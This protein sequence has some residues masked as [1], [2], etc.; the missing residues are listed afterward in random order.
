MRDIGIPVYLLRWQHSILLDRRYCVCVGT[1]H[2]KIVRFALGVSQGSISG[3]LLFALYLSTLTKEI[4]STVNTE[5]RTVEFADYINLWVRLNRTADSSYDINQTQ[6]ALNVISDWSERYGI[7]VSINQSIKPGLW[8]LFPTENRFPRSPVNL[9]YRG[10]PLAFKDDATMLG[11][12][13]VQTLS[14]ETHVANVTNAAKRKL[15]CITKIIGKDWGG[16]TGDTRA[17]C[18]S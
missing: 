18:L 7:N 14:F 13:F 17:A 5:V 4:I 8:L 2:S 6:R 12:T 9:T 16:S 15:A 3:P 1:S 11:V 10:T